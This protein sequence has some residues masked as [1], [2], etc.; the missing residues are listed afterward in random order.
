LG[1]ATWY[2]WDY[3]SR[4]QLHNHRQLSSFWGVIYPVWFYCCLWV[5]L[6]L[7]H[8]DVIIQTCN[9][10]YSVWLLERETQ[11]RRQI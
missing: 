9:S 1:K 4:V 11:Q 2:P 7:C 6:L 10:Q 5:V 3:Y 8:R